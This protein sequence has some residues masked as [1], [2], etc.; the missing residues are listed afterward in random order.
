M[1]LVILSDIHG[2]P[3]AL[4]AVLRDVAVR[5]SVNGYWVLG[6][7]VAQGY[8]PSGVLAR[9]AELPN[10]QFVRGNTDRYILSGNKSVIL[11][12]LLG[13][14]PTPEEIAAPHRSRT[15][16]WIRNLSSRPCLDP[17]RVSRDGLARL[18]RD[19]STGTAA[20]PAERHSGAW[21]S[22]ISRL[23]RWSRYGT[24]PF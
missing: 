12:M 21:R 24:S 5:G 18:A 10:A 4:D 3:I 17:R 22:R 14:H 20:H 11:A 9:L 8:D 15:C 6:D 1:R 16:S 2:N 23:R 7:L 13:R 19:A